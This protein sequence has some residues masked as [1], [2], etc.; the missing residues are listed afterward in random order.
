MSLFLYVP[1]S[2]NHAPDEG[3]QFVVPLE[4][5]SEKNA[6]AKTGVEALKA[7]NKTTKKEKRNFTKPRSGLLSLSLSLS[8]L[9]LGF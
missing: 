9:R 5:S 7:R 3:V 2:F 8:R 4:K 6:V 1:L